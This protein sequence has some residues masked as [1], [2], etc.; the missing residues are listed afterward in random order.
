MSLIRLIVLFFSYFRYSEES[1]DTILIA[2]TSLDPR[3]KQ[4]P[5]AVEEGKIMLKG[6]I[7]TQLISII[8]EKNDIISINEENSPNQSKKTRLSGTQILF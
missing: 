7:K 2:A 1:I 4:L 5:Y 8:E 6:P 3:F